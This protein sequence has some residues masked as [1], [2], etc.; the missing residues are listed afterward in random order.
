MQSRQFAAWLYRLGFDVAVDSSLCWNGC[1][2]AINLRSCNGQSPTAHR[3]MKMKRAHAFPLAVGT[4]VRLG[5]RIREC[6]ELIE[7]GSTLL[8]IGCS[9]GWLGPVVLARGFHD[10]VGLDRVIVNG[11]K[12]SDFLKLVEGS[13]FELPFRDGSFDA[14]CL[15]DVVEHLPRG[16]EAEALREISRVLKIKGRLYFSTPHASPIHT[17]LDPVWTLGHRHYRRATVRRL[18]LSAGF[19]IDRMFVA[20]GLVECLDH[21][22][23]LVHKHLLHRPY[24]QSDLIANLIERS[25]GRDHRL[26][27]TVFA[28][29]VR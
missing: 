23:L 17:P 21:V 2:G 12:K 27:M 25:H 6:A 18:L 4:Q 28:V 14:V 3:P 19:E 15:F 5:G 16:S 24:R 11:H 8:D 1:W 20:G 26:G 22:D 9:S 7:P 10:Y 13:V 29:A